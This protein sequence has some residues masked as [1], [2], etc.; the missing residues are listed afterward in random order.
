MTFVIFVT[1]CNIL[2]K[3]HDIMTIQIY[4]TYI[5]KNKQPASRLK[6]LE[7]GFV[8]MAMK[9]YE[10]R[11]EKTEVLF[12]IEDEFFGMSRL[13]AIKIIS[14]ILTGDKNNFVHTKEHGLDT[15][16]TKDVYDREWRVT[17]DSSIRDKNGVY[18]NGKD[19]GWGDIIHPELVNNDVELVTPILENKDLPLYEACITALKEAGAET[20][21]YNGLHVHCSHDFLGLAELK[22]CIQ[23][24]ATR[25]DLLFRFC[26]VYD[27]RLGWC[28]ATSIDLAK[29]VK[30]AS[31]MEEL[32][33]MWYG[34]YTNTDSHYNSTRYA[35][36]NLHS[37][38]EGKGIE[39]RL[40]NATLDIDTIRSIIDICQGFTMDAINSYKMAQYVH[41]DRTVYSNPDR[42]AQ[43]LETYIDRMK[44][45]KSTKKFLLTNCLW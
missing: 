44:L 40:F 38:F 14:G 21:Q 36:L 31:S 3:L 16:I 9:G 28:E 32:K 2:L 39:L 43:L 34:N 15:Y 37:F 8:I 20:S 41:I 19:R 45:N 10:K 25:Q 11:I 35:N 24:M 13:E 42:Q 4:N 29:S 1:L 17:S 18:Q 23:H 5:I 6:K 26:H 12:G 22:K 30:K 7:K 33:K 27:D